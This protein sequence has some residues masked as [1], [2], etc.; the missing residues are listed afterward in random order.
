MAI[1]YSKYEK[2]P[3]EKILLGFN[4]EGDLAVGST[5]IVNLGSS[6]VTVKDDISK[7]DLTATMVEPG[8]L[9]LSEDN[10]TLHARIIGGIA[11]KYYW[12]EFRAATTEG[13][14]YERDVKLKIFNPAE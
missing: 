5:D 11:G 1:K 8:S 6:T 14:L 10:L 2:Q 3:D 7:T 4:I 9:V 13:N 12:V